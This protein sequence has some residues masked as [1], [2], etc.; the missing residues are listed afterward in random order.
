MFRRIVGAHRDE[1][2]LCLYLRA[3][4]DVTLIKIP[5]ES[6][7]GDEESESRGPAAILMTT[8]LHPVNGTPAVTGSRDFLGRPAPVAVMFR[9]VRTFK[10]FHL[11]GCVDQFRRERPKQRREGAQNP[12]VATGLISFVLRPAEG[13]S[14]ERNAARVGPQR[15]ARNTVAAALSH[16]WPRFQNTNLLAQKFG[17]RCQYTHI[18]VMCT[19]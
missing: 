12:G 15:P 8:G 16:A 5:T 7:R 13:V 10:C 14:G 6:K 9:N 4:C 2:S 17:G 19:L 3:V 11:L 18:F 1:I